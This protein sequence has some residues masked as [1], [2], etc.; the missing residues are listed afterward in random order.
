MLSMLAL[1]A[2]ATKAA[3]APITFTGPSGELSVVLEVKSGELKY[4]LKRGGSTLIEP[5]HLGF[6]YVDRD[7]L[8]GLKSVRTVAETSG[9]RKIYPGYAYSGLDVPY[10]EAV[11]EAIRN[12]GE[13]VQ[14]TFRIGDSGLAWRQAMPAQGQ[15]RRISFDRAEWCLPSGVTLWTQDGGAGWGPCEGIFSAAPAEKL[16]GTRSGPVTVEYGDK[17]GYLLISESGNMDLGFAGVKYVIDGPRIRSTFAFD[18]TGFEPNGDAK[19]SPWR[20]VIAAKDLTELTTNGWIDSLAAEP[21]KKLFP[22]GGKDSWIKP[23][24]AAWSW[25]DSGDVSYDAQKRYTDMAAEFG[26]E[27]NLIDEGWEHWST[28]SSDK[29]QN[30]KSLVEYGK[31]KGVSQWVWKRWSEINDS[32]DDWKQ[33]GDFMDKVKEAGVVGM[34]IDFMDSNSQSRLRFY[35]AAMRKTAERHLMVNFHGANIPSGESITYPNQ[36]SREG[37]FGLE[38]TGWTA[39]PFTHYAALPFTRC[40]TGPADFTPGYFGHREDKLDGSTWSL[41]LATGIIYTSPALHW[42]SRP[43]DMQ[44]AFPEGSLQRQVIKAIPSVWDETQYLPMSKIGG[45]VVV[46]RRRGDTWFVAGL[47]GGPEAQATVKTTFLGK[48]KYEGVVITDAAKHDAWDVHATFAQK[49]STHLF[50]VQPGGGF[51]MMLKPAN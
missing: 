26:F 12:T 47:N 4:Q 33:M 9:T 50:R 11:V 30:I 24:R 23:G 25:W 8:S 1:C 42:V 5:S 32:R 31:A 22:A 7:S 51:V 36:L 44:E 43:Q 48:G 16:H 39:I 28:P 49:D 46:A 38:Q 34:K 14:I 35:D 40:A 15:N 18:L 17:R 20:T 29:W 27:N 37:I 19:W 41:Q 13:A 2:T 3:P 21:D 6:V 10:K 45:L